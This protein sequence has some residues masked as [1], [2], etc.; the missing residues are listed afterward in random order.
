MMSEQRKVIEEIRA[1]HVT[2]RGTRSSGRSECSCSGS[3]PGCVHRSEDRSWLGHSLA[4]QHRAGARWIRTLWDGSGGMRPM[5]GGINLGRKRRGVHIVDGQDQGLEWGFVMMQV[6][7]FSVL[8]TSE[9][10]AK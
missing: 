8:S 5:V 2:E 4:L 1:E 6:C 9:D 7:G 10:G 3:C